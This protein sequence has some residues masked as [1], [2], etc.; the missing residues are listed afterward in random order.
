MALKMKELIAQSGESK[1]TILY[2]VK[3]GLLPQPSKPKPNVHLYDE[4]SVEILRFIKYL[5]HNFNYSIAEIK[6]IFES[7]RFDF[8]GSFEAMVRSLEMIS[9]GR[10]Q[11]WYDR[12][13]FL[14]L[15]ELDEE[16]LQRYEAAGYLF[17]RTEGYSQKEVEI[18]G[19][20]QRAER[21][22][23][24]FGLL[25]AYVSSAKKLAQQ[26]NETGSR[27]LEDESSAHDARYELLFDLIL[28]LKP[29]IFNMHTVQAHREKIQNNPIE[30][31]QTQKERS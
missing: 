16:R 6:R 18:A 27:L 5:Q 1:S 31:N 3:E 9:G 15:T 11:Q 26:E 14:A 8:D 29:Y 20:L 28:T 22:G 7:N 19:I 23:L 30:K 2:Y 4:S 10:E 12:D 24:D 17:E 25:E 21:L 13:T